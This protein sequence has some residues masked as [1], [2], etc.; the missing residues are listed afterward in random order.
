MLDDETLHQVI[1][2]LPLRCIALIEDI[3]AAFDHAGIARDGVSGASTQTP[4]VSIPVSTYYRR[5]VEPGNV[6]LSGLL[7]ALDGVAAQEGRMLFA[8]TNCYEA[9]D[10]ALCRAGRMDIHVEF[11]M[12]SR[13]QAKELFRH[14]FLV[15]SE[16]DKEDVAASGV[17]EVS[18]AGGDLKGGLE[19]LR[20]RMRAAQE[21]LTRARID[22]LAERFAD[23]VPERQFSVASLQ[24]HLMRFKDKPQDA[25]DA[26]GEWIEQE[27]RKRR[28]GVERLKV[29]NDMTVGT[30]VQNKG[31]VGEGEA[32][33]DEVATTK[34]EAKEVSQS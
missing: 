18:K 15:E 19:V 23:A 13:W 4:P 5:P 2:Q 25:V 33:V 31:L 28:T 10:E 24:G 32:E 21:D 9:L 3:D 17:S 11:K 26:V 30:D 7:R 8:T 27:S 29:K 12:A 14:F 20:M 1:C 34:K 22:A 6:T 16:T